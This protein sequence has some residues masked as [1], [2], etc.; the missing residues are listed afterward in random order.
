MMRTVA[1][2]I[3]TRIRW[4]APKSPLA[5]EILNHAITMGNVAEVI[6][7]FGGKMYPG[8]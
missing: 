3:V 8:A 4:N 6:V 2:I 7:L 5:G 1:A